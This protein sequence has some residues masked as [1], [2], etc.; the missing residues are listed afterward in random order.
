M[1][2]TGYGSQRY[3]TANRES[4][5]DMLEPEQSGVNFFRSGIGLCLG[6]RA[7]ASL[8]LQPTPALLI[9]SKALRLSLKCLRRHKR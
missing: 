5:F 7:H 8:L 6:D 4:T 1:S 2:S 9:A 3:R